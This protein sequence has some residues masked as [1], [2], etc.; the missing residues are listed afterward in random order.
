MDLR[1]GETSK[2]A[3]RAR[4]CGN[5]NLSDSELHHICRMCQNAIFKDDY[6]S[7]SV[8]SGEVSYTHDC[9]LKIF[10]EKIVIQLQ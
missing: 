7:Q 9:K 2:S 10:L 5:E 8:Y 3:K 6:M 1:I 4:I